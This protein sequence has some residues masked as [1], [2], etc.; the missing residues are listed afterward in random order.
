[1]QRCAECGFDPDAH[2]IERLPAALRDL[3]RRYRPPFTRL[4]RGEDESILRIRPEPEVWS[5]AEYLAHAVDVLAFYRR[6]IRRVV[7][8]DRPRL[9]GRDPDSFADPIEIE[10]TL[11]RL[12][13]VADELAATLEGLDAAGWARVGI[14]LEGDER[15]V[16]VLARRAL[17]DAEHH[18]L[19]VGRGL[20]RVRAGDR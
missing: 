19:D 9:D 13:A 15:D 6:R 8:E 20:R 11:A 3:G 14:G 4:L 12:A 5:A 18:L 7:E 2:G 10:P 16:T 17:H 1:M